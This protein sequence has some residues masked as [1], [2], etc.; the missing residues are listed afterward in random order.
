MQP[1][2][3]PPGELTTASASHS[4]SIYLDE[5]TS[6]QQLLQTTL[7]R[8]VGAAPI[9]HSPSTP[10]TNF[11]D[12]RLMTLTSGIISGRVVGGMGGLI[13]SPS[14]RSGG[15]A[16]MIR[17]PMYADGSILTGHAL[18]GETSTGS[19]LQLCGLQ[20][21][22]VSQGGAASAA[23]VRCMKTAFH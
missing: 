16:A 21:A 10:A 8:E 5:Q 18:L 4:C 2:P 3:V 20:A 14:E 6:L 12:V 9:R 13:A 11:P 1:M 15:W 22:V 7:L 19:A 23:G 17:D